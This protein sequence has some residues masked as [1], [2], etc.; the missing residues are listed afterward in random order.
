MQCFA[1]LH[2]VFVHCIERVRVVREGNDTPY[3]CVTVEGLPDLPED[4]LSLLQDAEER[5]RGLM[6][7]LL[8]A[9]GSDGTAL[10]RLLGMSEEPGVLTHRLASMVVDATAARQRML[11]IRSPLQRCELLVDHVAQRMMEVTSTTV[12]DARLLN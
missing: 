9:L 1:F 6:T 8:R 2:N 10:S 12:D 7:G 11:E 5:L 3:R 4:D